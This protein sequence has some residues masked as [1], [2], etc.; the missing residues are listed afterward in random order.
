MRILDRQLFDQVVSQAAKSP[1]LRQNFNIHKDYA[2][3]CQRLLNALEPGTYVRPHR[4]LT[5]PKPECFLA[6]RGRM[7]AVL[8]FDSGEIDQVIEFCPAGPVFGLD[9]PAGAWHTII[10]LEPGALFFECKPGPYEPL[11]DKDWAGW[12]PTEG[13]VQAATYLRDLEKECLRKLPKKK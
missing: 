2:D 11:S 9:I 5:P 12:A 13:D 4:H 1:R 3:P 7:A 6:L 10:P 8:F